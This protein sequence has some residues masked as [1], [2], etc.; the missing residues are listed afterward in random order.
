MDELK[1]PSNPALKN[2]QE[3]VAKLEEE[4]GFDRQTAAE[5]SMLLGE[6][7]GE[8]FKAMRKHEPNLRVD[9][10]SKRYDVADELADVFLYLCA[11]AN[12]Y[13]IDL[14]HA[15]REK[16]EKNKARVWK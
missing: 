16:E 3:Y 9:E 1:L 8:L 10:N 15:F 4:R 13:H 7:I 12:Q 2:F 5:K 11:I 6:E 14:E